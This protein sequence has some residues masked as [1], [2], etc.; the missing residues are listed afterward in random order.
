MSVRAKRSKLVSGGDFRLSQSSD[1]EEG[2]NVQQEGANLI[3]PSAP[4][5]EGA[6]LLGVV[7]S[8]GCVGFIPQ[9]LRITQ[10][11]IDK[12]RR[13]RPPEKRFRFANQCAKSGCKQ[14]TGDRCGVIDRVLDFSSAIETNAELPECA[15]RASCRWH[16][17]HGGSACMVCPNVVTD[18]T[19]G[20]SQRRGL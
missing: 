5:K 2:S 19:R 1:P 16:Q 15:I 7:Q 12:A 11:F 14:W 6:L 17:Q 3:C 20:D 8:D 9:P 4:C 10:E 18:S 13:G